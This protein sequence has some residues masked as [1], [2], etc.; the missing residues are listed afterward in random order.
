LDL[1]EQKI[2]TRKCNGHGTGTQNTVG[3]EHEIES[4]IEPDSWEI[5]SL[6]CC[7][8]TEP[9]SISRRITEGSILDLGEQEIS[10]RK[11]NGHGT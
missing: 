8:G 5:Q 3:G 4:Q 1:G 2:S 9:L 11:C 7:W 10:T 6:H